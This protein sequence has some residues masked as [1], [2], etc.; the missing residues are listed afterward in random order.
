M[1]TLKCKL[2]ESGGESSYKVGN[3]V[4]AGCEDEELKYRNDG[5]HLALYIYLSDL[6]E[7]GLLLLDKLDAVLVLDT[8]SAS[9]TRDY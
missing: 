1:S 4:F 5:G 8:A 7:L 6:I 9:E 3:D 2:L